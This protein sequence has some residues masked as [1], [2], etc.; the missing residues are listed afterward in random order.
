MLKRVTFLFLICSNV[1]SSQNF[2]FVDNLVVKYPK[3]KTPEQLAE[4]ISKD[5]DKE[6]HQVRAAYVWLTVNFRYDLE[7]YRAGRKIIEFQYTTEVD[8]QNKLKEIQN[9]IVIDAFRKRS[10]VCEE[11]AQSLKKICDLL[12]IE[13]EVVKG[14][15]RNSPRDIG[16]PRG[17]TNHAWNVVKIDNRWIIIDPTWASGY[18]MNGRWTKR[19][20]DYYFDI[21]EESIGRTHFPDSKKWQIL[22]DVRSKIDYYNQ[23]IYHEYFLRN[24]LSFKKNITGT[25]QAKWGQ[26]IPLEIKGLSNTAEVYIG[27]GNER[28]SKKPIITKSDFGNTLLIPAPQGST[29]MFVFINKNLSSIFKVVV[30]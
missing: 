15:V 28:Y 8:K 30:R 25:L 17:D 20:S 13:S 21:P 7:Q 2:A 5:Y 24:N 19:L 10:G 29:E 11:Y 3:Y 4:R 6:L 22:W 12:N 16:R 27:F 9:K 14:N 23:P 18:V 26:K 1:L